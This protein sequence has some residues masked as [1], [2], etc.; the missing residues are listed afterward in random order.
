MDV[1][2][3]IKGDLAPLLGECGFTKN[4]GSFYLRFA[5]NCG[6]IAFQK[7]SRSSKDFVL[8]TLNLGVYSNLL[9][10]K[11]DGFDNLVYPD[12]EQCQW[13]SRIAAFMPGLP[14]YW[15]QIETTVSDAKKLTGL[16]F[17][18]IKTIVIPELKKD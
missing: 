18:Q 6:V 1:Y 4:G 14:D 9:G 2:N 10:E 13:A 8:F 17:E 15:W 16:I 12:V 5:K 3:Q 11:V 7:S